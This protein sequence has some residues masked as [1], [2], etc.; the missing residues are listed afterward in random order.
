MKRERKTETIPDGNQ[1]TRNTI[2]DPE[3]R[4]NSNGDTTMT[5][6][7]RQNGQIESIEAEDTSWWIV[8]RGG[9][10]TP[11]VADKEDLRSIVRGGNARVKNTPYARRYVGYGNICSVV[12][13]A[14]IIGIDE[15]SDQ[16]ILSEAAVTRLAE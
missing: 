12:S 8:A 6:V 10:P 4:F 5:K 9:K 1:D 13:A 14:E 11:L 3:A 2:P 16:P 15:G 7:T